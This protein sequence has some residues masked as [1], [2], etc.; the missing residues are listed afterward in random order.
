MQILKSYPETLT[1]KNMY[2][3]T[4]SP[5]TQKMTTAKGSTLEVAAWCLYDD[6]DKDGEVRR[7]LS[8]QT[9]EGEIF[10]TNSTTFQD[11][12]F[13]MVDLFDGCVS[14]IEVISGT[15]KGGREF[16]DCAYAG[17]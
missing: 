3:L 7:V 12:F 9:P 5:K 4:M 13:R 15:S 16:I 17:E 8:I 11:D 14:A 1:K 10:A 6:V 2:D